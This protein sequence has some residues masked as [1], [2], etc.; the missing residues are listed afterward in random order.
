MS[1]LI[2]PTMTI[3]SQALDGLT[4]QQSV[5]SSNLA[6]IDT[7]NYTPQTVDFETALQTEYASM[8][9][10]SSDIGLPPTTGTAANLAMETT[11]PRHFSAT[12]SLGNG[13]SASVSSVNENIRNDGNKVDLESEMTSLTETQVKFEADS[14]LIS[15]KF[16]MLY[17]V[18]GGH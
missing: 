7:P 2:D 16:T 5:I 15:G 11:D 18:L 9:N 13:S 10:S 6:N 4:S 8:T 12:G 3:L 1:G 14:R 17:D